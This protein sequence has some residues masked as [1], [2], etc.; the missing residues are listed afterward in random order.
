MKRT[1]VSMIAILLVFMFGIFSFGQGLLE[2]ISSEKKVLPEETSAEW[3]STV[4]QEIQKEEYHLSPSGDKSGALYE[5]PNRA[6]GFRACFTRDGVRVSPRD[7]K[8][9]KWEWG[10]ELVQKAEGSRLKAEVTVKEN[11]IEINREKVVEWYINDENGL[12]QGFTVHKPSGNG[13]ILNIDM[14]LTGNLH[15]KFAEDGQAIDFYGNGNVAVLRYSQLKVTDSTGEVLPSNFEGINGG[16]RIAIDD[17]SAAYPITVDPLVTSPAWTAEG[18]QEGANFGC[19]VGTAGDVNGDGYSDIIVGAYGYDNG[20]DSEGRAYVY[21]GGA[22]GLSASAGW[23]AESDQAEAFFGCSVGTAGDVNGDGYSDVIVGAYGAD[24]FA[25]KVYLYLGGAS[26]LSASAGWTRSGQAAYDY[27]GYSVATAGDVNGDGYSDVIVGAYAANSFVGKAY[28]YLGGAS[29]LSASAGWTTAGEASSDYF[30]C[31]VA[32]AGDVNGDGYS[33]VI[34]GAW[35][36]SSSVGKAYLFLGSASGLSVATSWTAVGETPGDGFGISVATAGDVNGDGYSDVIVGAYGANGFAGKAYLYLGGAS[37]LSASAGWTRSGQAAYD[38]FGYSVASAGDVNGDGYSDIIVGAHELTNIYDNEGRAYVYLG[39]PTGPAAT[40]GWT[41]EGGQTTAWFGCSV[42]TAGD[43]NGDGYSD[44]IVGAHGYS[45]GQNF[46]GRANVYLGASTGPAASAEWAATGEAA[47]NNFGYSVATAGDVNGDGYADVIVGAYGANSQAGKAY[48]YLGGPSGL[49]SSA[50]WTRSGEAASNRFGWSVA[51]AGDVN[52]DGYSD[53]IVS[54]IG[55]NGWAGKAYLYLGGASGLSASAG[56]TRSGEAANNYF[57]YSVTTAGDVNGDGY[58]DVIVGAYAVNSYA[59]KAYLYLGGASGLSA[60]A[61]W[62]RSGET[63]GDYFGYSIATAGDVNGDG[64]SDVIVGAYAA[65]SF[66]GKA[67]LYLGGA[68]GLSATAGWT[69]SGE[70]GGDYFGVS[71]ATAGDVNGDGYSDVIVGAYGANSVTGKA[72]LYLGGASGLSA[73]EGWTADGEVSW[74]FFGG[75]VATAGDVNGD[76]YSDVIVGAYAANSYTGKAY[77]YL[78]GASGL[79]AAAGW[80]ADGE[81]ADNYFGCSVATAGDVNG[82]GYSDV[83][84]GVN[85]ANDYAGRSNA[86]YGNGGAGAYMKPQQFRADLTAPIAPLGLAL[87]EQFRIG[88]RLRTPYGR[89]NVKLQ[90]Q[91][92]PL[93][94][95]FA[96]ALN[97]IQSD[98]SWLNSGTTGMMRQKLVGLTD[99]PGPFKWRAR[100]RYHSASSPFQQFGPWFTPAANGLQEADLRSAVA[101]ACVLPDEPCWIYLVTTDGTNHT[102]NFQDPNQANQRTGWN[103]RR[104]DNPSL[105]PKTSWPVVCSDCVDMDQITGNYQWTDSSGDTPSGGVWYYLV[106]AY[107]ASCPAE[108][109]FSSE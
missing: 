49:S 9:A 91:A 48:L 28:L 15:P 41:A 68:S 7:P 33:D 11:R 61:G 46:E 45:N 6:Q 93:W 38:C 1:K 104:S 50:G 80:T 21:L 10:L 76:G 44:I 67:Y 16:I 54:A 23:T 52:G 8:K 25:G 24:G 90:W 75:S 85:G 102:L 35:P 97:P 69:R 86:Y 63:A 36:Y 77:L 12:E 34:V 31:S 84:V 62:T 72:Y 4:Q 30:G 66:V 22:S 82:D 107:N 57:G 5:A 53:V 105:T 20:Q 37:G 29:G 59:G 47:N 94:V 106:T 19:S 55:A 87:E 101:A 17:S 51:T 103:I 83:I 40:A 78:G 71:V 60:S 32:T 64:Y 100:V 98:S 74:G 39:G 79:S 108:G 70:A 18:D 96:P 56:W 65:N 73:A 42:A 89:A 92:V 2:K 99:Q 81:A 13:G 26:G 58:S 14:R 27:F 109:P 43:V 95:S 88:L 3:W